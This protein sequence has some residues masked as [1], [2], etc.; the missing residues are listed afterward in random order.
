MKLSIFIVVIVVACIS[1]KRRADI[2]MEQFASSVRQTI[3]P[4]ELEAWALQT[5]LKTPREHVYTDI[6]TND[7]PKGI[8]ELMT[9]FATLQIEEDGST[10]NAVV[11][12]TRGGGF[13]HWGF[14]VGAPTYICGFGHT[15]E[16]WTNGIWFWTE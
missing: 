3:S 10:N 14:A 7:A 6:S 4:D 16:H 2:R 11:V 9:D 5:I 1:C 15:Q 8:R 12:Y 13:G